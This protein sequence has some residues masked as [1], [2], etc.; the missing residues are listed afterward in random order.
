MAAAVIV[1]GA[2]EQSYGTGGHGAGRLSTVAQFGFDIVG[3]AVV[4][5]TAQFHFRVARLVFVVT[6]GSPGSPA[7]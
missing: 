1:V 7:G 3:I 5:A 4:A 6:L 2:F